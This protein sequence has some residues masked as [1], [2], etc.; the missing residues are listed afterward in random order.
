MAYEKIYVKTISNAQNNY[1]ESM[2]LPAKIGVITGISAYGNSGMLSLCIN[3]ATD[4]IINMPTMSEIYLFGTS[5]VFYK[6]NE[7]LDLNSLTRFVYKSLTTTA[8]TLTIYIRYLP[9]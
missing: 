3:N 5:R 2:K 1:M 6:L 9:R 4:I 7:K 8:H